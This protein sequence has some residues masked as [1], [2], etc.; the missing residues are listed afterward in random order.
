M[1][2]ALLAV[3]AALAPLAAVADEP[4]PTVEPPR[5]ERSETPL[6]RFVAADGANIEALAPLLA[7]VIASADSGDQVD[8]DDEERALRRIRNSAIDVLGTEGYFSPRIAVQA[9][10]AGASRYL[11]ALDPGPRT[12]VSNVEVSLVGAI[13]KQPARHGELLGT[14]EL[15]VGQPF[16]DAAWASAKAKL[17]ARVQERD[18][19]AARLVESNADIDVDEGTARLRI[20]I[21]SG[22]AFTLGEIEIV[23]EEG[24]GLVRYSRTLVERF[25]DIKPGDRYDSVRLLE[26]QRKL[27]S[28]PYFSTV[29]VEVPFDPAQPD[30]A[31]IR[32]TLVEAKSKRL[33]AGLGYSTNT[34]PRIEG[35]YRQVG[36]FGFPYSLQ[37]GVGYD[38]TRT[39]GFADILLPP[40]PNGAVDSFGILGE[41]TDIQN[42]ITQRAAVG[43]ARAYA[44]DPQ[45][46]EKGY[47]YETRWSLKLQRETTEERQQDGAV[48]TEKFTNDTL[49]LAYSWTRRTVDSITNPR[50][51]DVLTLVGAGGV[52]RTGLSTLLSQ[53]FVYG[54]GRYVR[55][56]PIA[57]RDQLIM[58]G[59]IGHVATDDL[60]YVPIDYRFRAGGAG[61]VR[62]Y[63]Y[64]SL[65]VRAGDSVIGAS[66][67]AIV[68]TEYVR[69]FTPTWGAAA[70]VDVGDA[71]N[72]IAKVSWA[73]GYG[74]GPRWRTIAGPL[75]LDL[76]YGER[77]RKWRVHFTIAISF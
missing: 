16:R 72:N 19:P 35:I 32:V 17:L 74:V 45:A 13:E 44:T 48:P 56:F 12:R 34:G 25:N 57:E 46:H 42:L 20:Q 60:R 2:S 66:S 59:E 67:L 55:Y 75:A 43:A 39:I 37:T 29:L 63:P 3:S 47:S 36:L 64:Q 21:D 73:H 26:L 28:G 52:S 31:P 65:G 53:S 40:K 10:R 69:W 62:G 11:L 15:D 9:D 50:R 51:G 18:Y 58:R 8:A 30:R 7:R 4:Q 54:Y 38:K 49:T 76:A 27:Q 41:R 5:R 68:S 14:W 33:S 23:A 61:S 71:D 22:P 1:A 24:K 70:F 6:A 77:D